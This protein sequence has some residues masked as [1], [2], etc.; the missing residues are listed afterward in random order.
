VNVA[1]LS[2]LLLVLFTRFWHCICVFN[3]DMRCEGSLLLSAIVSTSC[4]SAFFLS[5]VSG[6]DII[7][8][9]SYRYAAYFAWWGDWMVT[10]MVLSFVVS[11]R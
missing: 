1:H 4:N 8:L 7:L 2:L 9:I 11:L 6:S 10:F 3:F 5:V